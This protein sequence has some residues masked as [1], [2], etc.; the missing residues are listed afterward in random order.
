MQRVSVCVDVYAHG[1]VK[2]GLFFKFH[3]SF[4]TV[5]WCLKWIFFCCLSLLSSDI[6]TVLEKVFLLIYLQHS[7][8]M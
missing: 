8:M 4:K 1:C 5:I 3:F 2:S 7:L 6:C